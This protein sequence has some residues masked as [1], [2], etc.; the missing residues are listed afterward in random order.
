MTAP[1]WVADNEEWWNAERFT[2]KNYEY[3]TPI[4][5]TWADADYN[6]FKKQIGR[7]VSYLNKEFEMRKQQHHIVLQFQGQVY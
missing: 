7:E 1:E 3:Y 2:D 6:A 5:W 4:D